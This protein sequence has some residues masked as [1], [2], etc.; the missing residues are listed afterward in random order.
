MVR[1]DM[2]VDVAAERFMTSFRRLEALPKPVLFNGL[3]RNRQSREDR[4]V[5]MHRDGESSQ[6]MRV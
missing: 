3:S 4:S 5:V 6:N 2:Q 1:D